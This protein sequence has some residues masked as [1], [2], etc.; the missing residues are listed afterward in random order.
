[1]TTQN[2]GA[3]NST[4]EETGTAPLLLSAAGLLI[5]CLPLGVV[6]AL[7]AGAAKKRVKEAGKS[8]AG[9]L[10]VAQI[11]GWL[12]VVVS[13]GAY[14]LG[15][16]GYME[17]E[18]EVKALHDSVAGERSGERLSDKVA[19]TLL[20][21]ELKLG[22]GVESIACEKPL[23]TK[24]TRA[25]LSDVKVK[26]LDGERTVTGCFAK[27]KRWFLLESREAGECTTRDLD[28][29]LEGLPSGDSP[30]ALLKA[31]EFYRE[32]EK[33]FQYF[34]RIVELENKLEKLLSVAGASTEPSACPDFAGRIKTSG[35][36]VTYVD[37]RWMKK[38]VKEEERDMKW[39][40]MTKES[41]RNLLLSNGTQDA[42]LKTLSDIEKSSLFAVFVPD[43]EPVWPRP[44]SGGFLGGEYSGRLALMDGKSGEILC[45]KPFQFE[46]GEKISVR[47]SRIGVTSKSRIEDQLAADFEERFEDA[48]TAS[49]KEMSKDQLKLG[50]SWLD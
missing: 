33:S 21:A 24:G 28:K 35:A 10:S 11:V 27:A 41:L 19:C 9:L 47:R 30:E 29:N 8:P 22:G 46:S 6:G 2:S 16:Q 34:V 50:M 14:G 32:D 3:Q 26:T 42:K 20:Q 12:S 1:M 39:K 17:N 38:G 13:L 49:L 31:E 44:S 36:E 15:A 37:A 45:Q 4:N 43:A 23:E 25:V 18:A 7:Q 5:C 48:A 40:F